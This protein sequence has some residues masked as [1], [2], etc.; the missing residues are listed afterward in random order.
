MGVSSFVKHS[1]SYQGRFNPNYQI[2]AKKWHHVP[3]VVTS[4]H[5]RQRDVM[6]G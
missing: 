5:A 1:H 4:S 6:E 3:D 2:Y